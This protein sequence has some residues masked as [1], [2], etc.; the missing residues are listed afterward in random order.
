MMAFY[1]TKSLALAAAMAVSAAGVQAATISLS[2]LPGTVVMSPSPTSSTPIYYDNVVGNQ[3]V[4]S[5]IGGSDVGDARSVWD[6]AG[7]GSTIDPTAAGAYYSAVT[8]N[9]SATFTFD[10]VQHVLDLVWGSVDTYNVIK[11]FSGGGLVATVTGADILAAGFAG[12]GGV[13]HHDSITVKIAGLDF[14]S[15]IMTTG[16]KDAFEFANLTAS[17]P[18]PAGGLLLI[19]ALG[20]VAALRRRKT[21]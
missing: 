13:E 11:F 15:F 5:G 6:S 4:G 20:A 8:G 14:D 10:R 18:L 7:T 16:S 12:F 19:S 3:I 2:A 17:V 21:A 1:N 9:A